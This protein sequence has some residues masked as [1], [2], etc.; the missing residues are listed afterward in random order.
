MF[1]F[2][3]KEPKIKKMIGIKK[4]YVWYLLVLVKEWTK[5]I[6]WIN[7][8]QKINHKDSP[9][10]IFYENTFLFKRI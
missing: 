2:F 3:F 5:I 8:Q 7:N 6:F 10:K 1:L 4:L 9:G